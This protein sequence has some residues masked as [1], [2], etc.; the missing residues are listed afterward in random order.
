MRAYV[1]QS[2]FIIVDDTQS[3]VESPVPHQQPDAPTLPEPI[4][5]PFPQPTTPPK[6]QP[7]DPP[8]PHPTT[9]P[10]PQ[11]IDPPFPQPTPSPKL[12]SVAT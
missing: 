1:N 11:P 8:F 4:D 9:P 2:H 10:E 5:P 6:P 7:I 3:N 12:T